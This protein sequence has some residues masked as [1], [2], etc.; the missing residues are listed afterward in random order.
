MADLA[1]A[2]SFSFTKLLTRQATTEAV[3]NRHWRRR[4]EYQ[5]GRHLLSDLFGHGGQ[6]PDLN[7]E[8]PNWDGRDVVSV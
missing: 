2:G 4:Q 1:Q 5:I 8:E 7:N 3:L 6:A